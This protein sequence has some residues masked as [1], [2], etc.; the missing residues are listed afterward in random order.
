[1]V[2]VSILFNIYLFIFLAIETMTAKTG[3]FK[4]FNVFIK[5]LED[6]LYQVRLICFVR[7]Y[8]N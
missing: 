5:M 4:S 6:A 2:N 3:N 7:F 8:L 1:M